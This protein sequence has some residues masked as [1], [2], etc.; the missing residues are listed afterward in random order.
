MR[1]R[2]AEWSRWGSKRREEAAGG[3][4]AL[5]SGKIAGGCVTA[6][7]EQSPSGLAGSATSPVRGDF[8]GFARMPRI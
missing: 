2:H 6:A 7:N 4:A 8:A 1:Y 5:R 3:L